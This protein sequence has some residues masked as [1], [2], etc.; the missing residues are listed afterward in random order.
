MKLF[1]RFA[2]V[3]LLAPALFAAD[4]PKITSQDQLPR[5]N[6]PLKG[7]VTIPEFTGCGTQGDD[8]D[9]LLNGTISGP[10]NMLHMTQG[11]LGTW[12]KHKPGDCQGCRPPND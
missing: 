10:G 6:Y 3:C 4:K 8:L 11:I 2:L 9:P 7:K 5:F 12:N 1:P